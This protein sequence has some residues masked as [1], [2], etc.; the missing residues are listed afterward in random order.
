MKTIRKYIIL[1]LVIL[2]YAICC[3]PSKLA[4]NEQFLSFRFCLHYGLMFLLLVVYAILWQQ[5][6]KKFPLTIAY[7]NKAS[8]ILWSMLLGLMVFNEKITIFN[9]IGSLIVIVGIIIMIKGEQ[10]HE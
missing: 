7:A 9:I 4:S 10:S 6:L 3:V 8:A 5:I 2:I 1:Q